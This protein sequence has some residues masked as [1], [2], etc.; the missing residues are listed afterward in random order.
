MKRQ[1]AAGDRFPEEAV[2][3]GFEDLIGGSSVRTEQ[4]GAGEK[5]SRR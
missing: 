3:E 5:Q 4:S 2:G 1:R